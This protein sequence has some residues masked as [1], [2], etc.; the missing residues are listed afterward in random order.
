MNFY[1]YAYYEPDSAVPFYVG[2]GQGDRAYQHLRPGVRRQSK[3]PFHR[4]IDQ[5]LRDGYTPDIQILAEDLIEIEAMNLEIKYI[6]HFG[7]RED[8]GSLL[9]ITFG[10]EGSSGR[11]YKHSEE[12]RQKM[13][14][15]HRVATC[16]R[17]IR[18]DARPIQS[19]FC[20][21]IIKKYRCIQEAAEDGY[22][23][24]SISRVLRKKIYEHGGLEWEYIKE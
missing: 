20:G 17:K 3:T 8:G 12:T 5:M 15:N 14:R 4:K 16:I 22:N 19:T 18:S 1:V 10:G 9:N 7:R 24:G 2:K 6:K 11:S 13:R 23:T 21:I